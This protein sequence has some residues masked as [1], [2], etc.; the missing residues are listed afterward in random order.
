MNTP[1]LFSPPSQHSYVTLSIVPL[2]LS[3]A[4]S[5]VERLHRHNQPVRGAKFCVGVADTETGV[6]RG[7]AIVGRPIA[8]LLQD[9]VT[10]EVSRCCTD[11]C[12]N[13]CSMLYNA[14]RSAAFAQG[15]RRLVTYTLQSEAMSS[16][17]AAG[18]EVVAEVEPHQGKGWTSR[19]GRKDQLVSH[20]PK[21]R[22]ETYARS[23][24]QRRIFSILLPWQQ[25]SNFFPPPKV[26][27]APETL[28]FS[29]KGNALDIAST[30]ELTARVVT[31]EEGGFSSWDVNFAVEIELL[32]A[33]DC[34]FF[35]A[36]PPTFAQVERVLGRM[37][38]RFPEQ[39][40]NNGYGGFCWRAKQFS[41]EETERSRRFSA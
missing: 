22:W 41:I 38:T 28:V 35:V 24:R 7:V 20:L 8:R 30:V 5:F 4:N 10:L 12:P 31:E 6:V 14:A 39:L 27:I 19:P 23:E 40:I 11:G 29:G 34:H 21:Y 3:E 13:A 1:Q 18:W 16:L 32:R 15:N 33:S 25:E 9:G 26:L 17:K 36:N 2:P 37:A